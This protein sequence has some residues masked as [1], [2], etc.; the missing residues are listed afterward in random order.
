MSNYLLKLELF[1]YIDHGLLQDNILHIIKV[2][3]YEIQYSN[4]LADN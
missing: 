3:I 2:F 1:I 4:S